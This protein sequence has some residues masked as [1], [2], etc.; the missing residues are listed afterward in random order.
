[1]QSG[2]HI[3][4]DCTIHQYERA[5]SRLNTATRRGAWEDL[6]GKI[7]VPN[8]DVEGRA[9]SDEQQVDGIERFFDYLAY[10]F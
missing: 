9:E 5:R 8:D 1:M 2:E 4:W 3:V 10:Q 6:D 7:W